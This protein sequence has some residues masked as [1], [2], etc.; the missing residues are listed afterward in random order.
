[1]AKRNP[2]TRSQPTS[3][4][5]SYKGITLRGKKIT[6]TIDAPNPQSARIKLHKQGITTLHIRQKRHTPSWRKSIKSLDITLFF[7]QLATM[8]SAG[9]PL[10][11]ALE[12]TQQNSK[13]P[14]LSATIHS[15]K[16]DIESG[17]SFAKALHKHSAF[18]RLSVALV[19]AGEQSGSLD[20]MLERIASH[21]E[22]LEI[23]K[24]KLKKATRYPMAVMMI[25]I[26]VTVILLVKVVPI[27]AKTF[28]DMGSQL[29]LPT[30]II[31]T[32]S[33]GLV[34][35]FWTLLAVLGIAIIG[36]YWANLKTNKVQDFLD[37]VSLKLPIIKALVKKSALAR[38]SRTLATTFGAGVPLLT[39]L[40]LSAQATNHR[41]FIGELKRISDKV[42]SGQKLSQAIGQSPLF[43][44][45]T[46]QMIDVGEESGKLTQMLDKVADYYEDE[47]STQIDGFTS[48]IEP[49][50]IVV[51]GIVVGGVVVAMYLPIFQIGMNTP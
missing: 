40:E 1:M 10:T 7:R 35:H 8:L 13:S 25:A 29:P 16:T 34:A 19:E 2:A 42:R 6:G 36:L 39:A 27:F 45:M 12:I 4:T 51:L 28:A 9:I 15:I 11:Q 31:M 43:L 47:V 30:R 20:T 33:D 24:N 3:K 21:Q 50:I 23:L 26:I 14:M 48:L 38:F 46:V 49:A 32:L 37:D 17:F 18:S 44:P 22:S 41:A 5:F